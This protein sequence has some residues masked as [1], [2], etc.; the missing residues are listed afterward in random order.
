M[1]L[2]TCI[3]LLVP[4]I[5]CQELLCPP[6]A[7][8]QKHLHPRAKD[9]RGR[10]IRQQHGERRVPIVSV[11]PRASPRE[12]K[13]VREHVEHSLVAAQS[14]PMSV[15][16]MRD[17]D[18]GLNTAGTGAGG[19]GRVA[20]GVRIVYLHI[21]L[22]MSGAATAAAAAAARIRRSFIIHSALLVITLCPRHGIVRISTPPE[23]HA[24]FLTHLC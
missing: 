18:R 6:Y 19:R 2:R 3:P 24:L 14:L 5:I 20:R 9:W 7:V 21:L 4:V 23:Q 22:S 11:R 17:A 12:G 1:R 8:S 10:R 15:T 13:G 16:S